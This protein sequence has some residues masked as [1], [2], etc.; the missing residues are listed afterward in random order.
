MARLS[1]V[2]A[3][4]PYGAGAQTV[5]R[6]CSSGLQAIITGAMEITCGFSNIVVAGG[7]ESMTNIPFYLRHARYGY[8]TVSYTHLDV[9]KRQ[10]RYR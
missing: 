9:Y 8:R 2:K 10:F 7:A 1:S 6:L 5:N 4:I 3:G